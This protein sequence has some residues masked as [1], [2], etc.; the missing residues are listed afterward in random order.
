[1]VVML[2]SPMLALSEAWFGFKLL[3]P[4]GY[5]LCARSGKINIYKKDGETPID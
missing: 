5:L 4:C 1:M 3:L 2:A